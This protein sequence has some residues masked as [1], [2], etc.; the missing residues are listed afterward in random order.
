[1]AKAK[2]TK[3]TTKKSPAK[4]TTNKVTTKKEVVKVEKVEKEEKTENQKLLTDLRIAVLY[5]ICAGCW[6]LSGILEYIS[7]KKISY[8]DYIITIVLAALAVVYFRKNNKNK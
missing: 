1:M 6:L 5:T 2:S 4:K 7:S 3:K 8:V